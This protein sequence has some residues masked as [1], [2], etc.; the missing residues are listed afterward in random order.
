[1]SAEFHPI[2]LAVSM[3]VFMLCHIP[4]SWRQNLAFQEW[5]VGVDQ[6]ILVVA[7]I[8]YPGDEAVAMCYRFRDIRGE[9]LPHS[10]QSS[11]QGFLQG[12]HGKSGNRHCR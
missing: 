2:V 11:R 12:W 6:T 9:R 10:V 1:M 7:V 4:S 8:Q 3:F 5:A